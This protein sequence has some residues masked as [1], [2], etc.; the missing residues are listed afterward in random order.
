MGYTLYDDLLDSSLVNSLP[1]SGDS[2]LNRLVRFEEDDDL[3][4]EILEES[5]VSSASIND[6]TS[7]DELEGRSRGLFCQDKVY[8]SCVSMRAYILQPLRGVFL[9]N[10]AYL[11]PPIF[12]FRCI[13]LFFDFSQLL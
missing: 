1:R 2:I 11:I 10:H 9:V 5:P 12:V 4:D 7:F 6:T 3:L 8:F 13:F